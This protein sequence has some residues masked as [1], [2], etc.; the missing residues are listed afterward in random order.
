MSDMGRWIAEL[1]L[2]CRHAEDLVIDQNPLKQLRQGWQHR[3]LSGKRLRCK[4]FVPPIICF[5]TEVALQK[6]AHCKCPTVDCPPVLKTFESKA[7]AL[8][9]PCREYAHWPTLHAHFRARSDLNHTVH[10][11]RNCISTSIDT[12]C[13]RSSLPATSSQGGHPTRPDLICKHGGRLE[14]I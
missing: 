9:R 1:L 12:R 7:F 14:A 6:P 11:Y 8:R 3:L 4:C 2:C 13:L 10:T 5:G